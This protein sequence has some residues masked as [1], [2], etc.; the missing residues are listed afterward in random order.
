MD[1]EF[2]DWIYWHFFTI[3]INYN[4][5]HIEL[6]L[7]DVC[8]ANLSEESVTNLGMISITRIHECTAF[9]ELSR[10]RDRTHHVQGFHYCFL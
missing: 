3:T 8:I 7:N 1:S 6:L 4:S 9:S 2:D 5:S 10:H